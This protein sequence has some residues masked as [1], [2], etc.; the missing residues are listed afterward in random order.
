MSR[1]RGL[2]EKT[3]FIGDYSEENLCLRDELLFILDAELSSRVRGWFEYLL[4][5]LRGNPK[6]TLSEKDKESV[7]KGVVLAGFEAG[8]EQWMSIVPSRRFVF[9]SGY[10]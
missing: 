4:A 7:Y 6:R 2:R 10:E 5:W 1:A 9:G 3:K 8:G